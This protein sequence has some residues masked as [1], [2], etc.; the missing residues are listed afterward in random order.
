MA[1]YLF[2]TNIWSKWFRN[3]AGIISKVE[4]LDRTSQIFLSSIVWGEAIYGA[5]ANKTDKFDFKSYSNFIHKS[6]PVILPINGN[7]S[8]V[9]GELR[10]LLFEKYIRKGKNKHPEQ[11]IDPVTATE[12]GIEEN[13]LWIVAQAMAYNL[14]LITNDKMRRIFSI[15]PKELEYEIWL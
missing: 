12:I 4:Q 6:K 15:V 8:E 5:K 2:D 9:Y 3:D 13:D 10:A 1:T 7:V 11:L 14:T